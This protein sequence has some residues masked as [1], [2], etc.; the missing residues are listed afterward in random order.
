[1][2]SLLECPRCSRLAAWINAGRL[3]DYY[4]AVLAELINTRAVA[5]TPADV[6]PLR[7][8][9]IDDVADLA[10]AAA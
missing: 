7:W 5:M 8:Y 1:M 4:E 10:R 6:T 9:E 2:S 3:D